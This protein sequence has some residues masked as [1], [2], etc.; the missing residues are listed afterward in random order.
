MNSN[1]SQ[2]REGFFSEKLD[3][4]LIILFP[5]AA[6]LVR[7]IYAVKVNPQLDM[8]SERY[9]YL[10]RALISG[11][12]THALHYHY[13]PLLPALIAL[14]KMACGNLETA[15]RAVGVLAGAL[16]VLPVYLLALRLFGRRAAILAS[17]FWAFRFFTYSSFFLAEALGTLLIFLAI[18]T[19]LAAL[20][21]KKIPFFLFTGILYGLAFLAKPE[22]WAYFLMFLALTIFLSLRLSKGK[23][24]VNMG[25]LAATCLVLIAGYFLMAGPYLWAYH[26]DT[27]QFSLNP[28]AHTLFILH[29]LYSPL[30]AQY[31][32]REDARGYYTPAERIYLEG[33]KTPLPGSVAKI[34]WNNRSSFP[35]IYKHRLA[36]SLRYIIAGFY[37]QPI[38]PFIWPLLVLAGLWPRLKPK[39]WPW[40]I[41]LHAF[42]LIPVFSVPLFSADYPRFYFI[43]LPWFMII[44]GRGT[45]RIIGLADKPTTKR[46][47]VPS[48]ALINL[49][50]LLSASFTIAKARPEKQ[51]WAEVEYR[52]MVAQKVKSLLST[53]CGFMAELE[54]QSIWYLADL[55][56]ERQEILP[57]ADLSEV[58]L[59]MERTGCKYIVFHP[60]LYQGRYGELASLL[61][62]GFSFPRLKEIFRGSSPAG[63]T[64]V[65]YE[66]NS[67]KCPR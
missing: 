20:E 44:L 67:V 63:E 36:L 62:P 17:D 27:G 58:V 25:P 56:P 43:M 37:L 26:G 65:I 48:M 61:K 46:L 8:D 15:S 2:N 12:Y 33:N 6:L 51:Y 64:Y 28:K 60:S 66:L 55:P 18:L 54:N 23:R 24:G 5:A 41:Y 7:A 10:A 31:D 47:I 22:A 3:F 57:K 11:D 16:T 4:I 42:A 34:L 45:A 1:Q 29:N 13:P 9:I 53:G 19:G 59:F 35:G 40:E 30:N 32:I 52:R 21:R 39:T 50:F 14:A 38:A 49:V